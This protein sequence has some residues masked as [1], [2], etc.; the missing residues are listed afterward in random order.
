[1]PIVQ[2]AQLWELR[3]SELAAHSEHLLLPLERLEPLLTPAVVQREHWERL[4]AMQPVEL[5]APWV[6]L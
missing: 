4:W 5:T 1:V 6:Q 2:W 3:P